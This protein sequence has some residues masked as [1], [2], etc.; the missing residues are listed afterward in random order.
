MPDE[1][2]QV[3]TF[4]GQLQVEALQRHQRSREP[5]DNTGIECVGCETEIPLKRRQAKPGCR[6]CIDC[7]KQFET[8]ATS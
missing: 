7:Q 1:I 2:D 5:D 8:E 6:R 3:Q 4:V